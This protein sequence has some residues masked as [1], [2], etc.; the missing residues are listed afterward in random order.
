[1]NYALSRPSTSRR[2]SLLGMVIAAHAGAALIFLAA[3][4]VAPQVAEMPLIVDLLSPPAEATKEPEAK[5]LPMA[6][7]PATWIDAHKGEPARA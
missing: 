5:P 4:T 1:M 7:P 3:K 6:K 2:S